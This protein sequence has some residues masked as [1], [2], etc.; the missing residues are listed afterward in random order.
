MIVVCLADTRGEDRINIFKR[1]VLDQQNLFT[2][3]FRYF[4]ALD[5][6]DIIL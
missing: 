1:P 6:D 3:Y 2:S 5:D 4:P